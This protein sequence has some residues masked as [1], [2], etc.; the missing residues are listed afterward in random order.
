MVAYIK[1][2]YWNKYNTPCIIQCY[3]HNYVNISIQNE[4]IDIDHWTIVKCNKLNTK[5]N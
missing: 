3:T 4:T 1:L 2:E 5:K